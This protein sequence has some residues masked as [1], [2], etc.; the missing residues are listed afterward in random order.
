MSRSPSRNQASPP[1][2][3]TVASAFQVSSARPQPRSS[4]ASAG[5]GVEDAVEIGRDVQAEH[6]EVVADVADRR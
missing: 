5:E 2:S 4:S 3:A 6:L 1:S